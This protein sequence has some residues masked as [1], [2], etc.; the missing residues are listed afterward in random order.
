MFRKIQEP[1]KQLYTHCIGSRRLQHITNA[2]LYPVKDLKNFSAKR[3]TEV[4][5]NN[6]ITNH[7]YN[8]VLFP[9]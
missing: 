1:I 8:K 5:N 3:V 2:L 7:Q 4:Y 6:S 9:M